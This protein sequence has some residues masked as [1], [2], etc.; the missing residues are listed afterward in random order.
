MGYSR[1]RNAIE[2]HEAELQR[3]KQIETAPNQPCSLSLYVDTV[4][5][6]NFQ[7]ALFKA[8]LNI[9]DFSSIPSESPLIYFLRQENPLNSFLVKVLSTIR[10]HK[11]L[12][13]KDEALSKKDCRNNT[14]NV[15]SKY[16]ACSPKQYLISFHDDDIKY[17]YKQPEAFSYTTHTE[18]TE[19]CEKDLDTVSSPLVL[20]GP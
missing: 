11:S 8:L 1:K 17:C 3:R 13:Y 2:E 14:A 16:Y 9:F 7:L 6:R 5:A 10:C 20:K 19:E 18:C 12:Y 4:V 15:L